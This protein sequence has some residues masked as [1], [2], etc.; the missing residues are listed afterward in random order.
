MFCRS[1]QSAV[2]C[3]ENHS[4]SF[5]LPGDRS[6]PVCADDEKIEAIVKR[7]AE[8]K[9]PYEYPEL[10]RSLFVAGANGLTRLQT[11]ANDS[12]AI[13][14]A[15]EAVNLT[16]PLELG[17]RPYRPDSE[18]LHWFLGFLQGGARV[19]PPS[20]WREAVLTAS[21]STQQHLSGEAESETLS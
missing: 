4:H 7:L 14:S 19:S 21:E 11:L 20:W 9:Y 3:N 12:I 10:Y 2:V 16:V 8:V 13:Q 5:R 1:D 17:D 6:G 18:K 15:W